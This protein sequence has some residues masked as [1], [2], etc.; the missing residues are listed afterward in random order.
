MDTKLRD[1][2][3]SKWEKYFGNTEL[4]VTFFYSHEKVQTE[5]LLVTGWDCLIGQIQKV[6][7][8]DSIS[9][10]E[11]SIGCGGGKRYTGYG[12]FNPGIYHFLSTGN[13]R[14]L[15]TPELA[16]TFVDKLEYI[17]PPAEYITFKRW[18]KIGVNNYPEAVIFFAKPD[19]LAGL[20]TLANFDDETGN[21]VIAPFSSGC[22]STIM[23]AYNEQ[24]KSDPKSI[25]GMFDVSARPYIGKDE[26]TFAIPMKKFELMIKNMDESFLITDSWKKV[27][28][29]I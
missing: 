12:A 16:K 20:F 26:L 13:E 2:F 4:P 19:I 1:D 9:F 23:L 18:D 7:K 27:K 17:D 25:L 3:I 29:R 21:A 8:G 22:G 28:R 5:E 10:S 14:Y 11:Q 24:Q 6:R 15:K